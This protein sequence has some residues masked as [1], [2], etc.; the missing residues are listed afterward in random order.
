MSF[1]RKFN[2]LL[3]KSDNSLYEL[4]YDNGIELYIYD[5]NS[6]LKY[7]KKFVSGNYNFSNAFFNVDNKDSVYGVIYT[8]DNTLLYTYINQQH[9]YKS[10]LL[11]I[12]NPK[13]KITF[14]YIKKIDNKIHLFYY[15]VDSTRNNE[16][17][18]I[19]Y[20]YDGHKWVKAELDKIKC[21]ILSNFIVTFND[22]TPTIFYLNDNKGYEEV[23]I[24]RFDEKTSS[25]D[26]IVQGTNTGKTKVYL[27][28]I[29]S[30]K[31]LY[32]IVFS[33][34]S[35]DRYKCAYYSGELVDN[36][37]IRKDYIIIQ[38]AVACEFPHILKANN[39]L[40]IQWLEFS[41][42]FT[43]FSED[44]GS[45]WSNPKFFFNDTDDSIIR[46]DYKS[47]LKRNLPLDVSYIFSYK[48]SHCS[49]GISSNL[50]SDEEV[51]NK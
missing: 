50:L 21:F 33:E 20:Y 8:K 27:S 30:N 5:K 7:K 11:K 44:N 40:Y 29:E 31:N 35:S 42:L 37:F 10:T 48:T 28:V 38:D 3:G 9:I 47:N 16:C 25:W 39:Q 19:H 36:K 6:K 32:H 51:N 43:S 1:E 12:D 41:E 4:S 14:P 24:T 34:N 22:N 45:T 26:S 49:L 15:L 13:L 46:Y 2:T 18:L 17:T 23:F